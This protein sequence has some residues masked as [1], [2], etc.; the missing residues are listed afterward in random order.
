MELT[1]CFEPADL[2]RDLQGFADA[3]SY[4]L[5]SNPLL[6]T[7][8]SFTQLGGMVGEVA[9]RSP[10]P[11]VEK[12]VPLK[13]GPQRLRSVKQGCKNLLNL[14]YAANG[15]LQQLDYLDGVQIILMRDDSGELIKTYDG[16]T[17]RYR[18]I[19]RNKRDTSLTF[20]GNVE[21]RYKSWPL[22]ERHE[23]CLPNG[24]HLVIESTELKM[25]VALNNT[26]FTTVL[27]QN[28]E[29]CEL[30]VSCGDIEIRDSL[31][32]DPCRLRFKYSNT[33]D[34]SALLVGSLGR[35]GFDNKGRLQSV[36]SPSGWYM[37]AMTHELSKRTIWSNTG[38]EIFEPRVAN[39]FASQWDT[40]GIRTMFVP[41][42]DLMAWSIHPERMQL[43]Q[44]DDSGRVIKV[45]N[46]DG[47]FYLI[48]YAK[49]NSVRKIVDENDAVSFESDKY[50]RIVQA[51][52]GGGQKAT[53]VYGESELDFIQ[54][55]M[56]K[57][58]PLIAR[59]R[60]TQI[61]WLHDNVSFMLPRWSDLISKEDI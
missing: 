49:S 45:R 60:L 6:A 41:V 38:C 18:R 61:W 50:G 20:E 46:A 35:F 10:K 5:A 28:H 4:L 53:F 24:E 33:K 36:V 21:F 14:S 58:L 31:K 47:S 57:A 44:Y 30:L 52:W 29:P 7:D 25:N 51:K 19:Q 11:S 1:Y 42:G 23:C 15:F 34:D 13:N 17:N 55:D 8:M 22:D 2:R 27:G 40:T 59:M 43:L 32:D 16:C 9:S 3:A 48:E 54:L 56:R 37:R 12:K 39:R 26:R